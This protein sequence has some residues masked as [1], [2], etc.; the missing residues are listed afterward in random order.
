MKKKFK[1]SDEKITRLI[2]SM[3]SAFAS[4]MI[5]VEGQKVDYMLREQ[6]SEEGDSGW[7][8]YGGGETQDYRDK[9]SNRSIFDLNTIANYDADIIEFLTYPPG[10]EIKR[11]AN[12][13]F[14]VLNKDIEKPDVILLHPVSPGRVQLT[15]NWSIDVNSLMLRRL[16]H[17]S[18]VLWKPEF[19]IWINPYNSDLDTETR[20]N[21]IKET[22]SA[23][24]YNFK[25][26]SEA[27]FTKL[28]YQLNEDGQESY[29][30]FAFSGSDEIHF[31]IYYDHQS[32]LKEIENMWQTIKSKK[33]S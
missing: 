10:T 18:L 33:M 13:K 20:V 32:A 27:G 31:T 9:P 15:Q 16:E 25:E 30:I 21:E 3:G 24:A 28:S 7:T 8:F 4:D 19:T 14:E 5:T 29:Y 2:P 11:N 23:K 12:D 1:L 26:E 22:K 17:A 6:P